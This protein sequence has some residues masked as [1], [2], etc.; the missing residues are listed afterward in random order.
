MA[1]EEARERARQAWLARP[2]NQTL[3]KALTDEKT[4]Q[5]DRGQMVIRRCQR[6]RTDTVLNG[7]HVH[8]KDLLDTVTEDNAKDVLRKELHFIE[9]YNQMRREY[10]KAKAEKVETPACSRETKTQL[11]AA[12]K[13]LFDEFGSHPDIEVDSV[14]EIAD[15]L[16]IYSQTDD[17]HVVIDTESVKNVF[18]V[19]SGKIIQTVEH[20]TYNDAAAGGIHAEQIEKDL[21]MPQGLRAKLMA[22]KEAAMARKKQG[23]Q[24][25]L[26]GSNSVARKGSKAAALPA[27]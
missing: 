18:D 16:E 19:E 27:P 5:V 17:Q 24:R 22:Q 13:D 4:S 14:K 8:Y 23:I 7:V 12:V 11:E 2:V 20:L 10:D 3:I 6:D 15:A 1:M 21:K 25:E 9:T 26:P